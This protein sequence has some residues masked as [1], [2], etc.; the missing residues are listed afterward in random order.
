[1]STILAL[2]FGFSALFGFG[3]EF[4]RPPAYF[5]SDFVKLGLTSSEVVA[6]EGFLGLEWICPGDKGAGEY[7]PTEWIAQGDAE[8]ISRTDND[9]CYAGLSFDEFG[10]RLNTGP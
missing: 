1:M 7:T 6:T 9:F 4:P 10:I 5:G 8:D 3:S 2:L